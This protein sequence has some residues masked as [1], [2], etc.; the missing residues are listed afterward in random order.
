VSS[1]VP[2]LRLVHVH[3]PDLSFVD[4]GRGLEVTA[5][6]TGRSGNQRPRQRT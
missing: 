5:E 2:V 6:G 4:Q 3:Q 1:A